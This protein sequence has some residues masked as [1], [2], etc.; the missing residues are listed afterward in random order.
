[1]LSCKKIFLQVSSCVSENFFYPEP[2]IHRTTAASASSFHF[3]LS[4]IILGG[5]STLYHGN[6]WNLLALTYN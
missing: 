5:V 1:M 6:C 4:L 3:V 2:P